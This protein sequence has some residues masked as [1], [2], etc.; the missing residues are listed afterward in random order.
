MPKDLALLATV[1]TGQGS[2]VADQLRQFQL[3]GLRQNF[4]FDLQ[5]TAL[6][7]GTVSENIA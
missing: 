2:D 4:G 3:Q 5:D 6:F 1:V 7:R